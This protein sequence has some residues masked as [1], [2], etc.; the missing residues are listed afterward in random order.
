LKLR[1]LRLRK[2]GEAEELLI[3]SFALS[4]QERDGCAQA[5]ILRDL[6][7]TYRA[8][9]K[10]AQAVRSIE[11]A[12]KANA[13]TG[14]LRFQ[15]ELFLDLGQLRTMMGNYPGALRSYEE[16]LGVETKRGNPAR[17]ALVFATH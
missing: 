8:S 17:P 4:R 2:F 6:S 5:L 11:E 9:N 10:Y 3:K 13:E 14:R 12:I 15:P 7:R 1:R 16:T